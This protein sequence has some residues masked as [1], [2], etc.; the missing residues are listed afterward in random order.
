MTRTLGH[1][2]ELDLS[3]SYQGQSL[4]RKYQSR[5]HNQQN[6]FLQK[7][8]CEQIDSETPRI[9]IL[10]YTNPRWMWVCGWGRE[11]R[12]SVVAY[13]DYWEGLF[14]S[15]VSRSP[16]QGRR[17]LKWHPDTQQQ[18][19]LFSPFITRR[20]SFWGS[21]QSETLAQCWFNIGPASA[22]LAQY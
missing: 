9:S 10:G 13:P 5:D 8:K 2:I 15:C 17:K 11:P 3:L 16:G 14:V 22:T 19:K 18:F 4:G 20:F 6:I 12:D 1:V 21:H 7:L